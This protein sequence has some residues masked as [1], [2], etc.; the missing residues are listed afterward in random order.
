MKKLKQIID[1]A[2]NEG[3][4]PRGLSLTDFRLLESIY[5]SLTEK[6]S[7]EFIQA[8]ILP[9]LDRCKIKYKE[10]GIGWVICK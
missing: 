3:K 2:Y 9:I 1:K 4:I 8:A 10:R 5:I 6:R 7:Y